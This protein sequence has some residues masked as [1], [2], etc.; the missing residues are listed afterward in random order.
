M[1]TEEEDNGIEAARTEPEAPGKAA[2][3]PRSPTGSS[4]D[5]EEKRRQDKD[6][7]QD[8]GD[9]EDEEKEERRKEEVGNDD[10]STYSS[11]S[12][13]HGEPDMEHEEVEEAVPGHELDR[14]LSRVGSPRSLRRLY[15]VSSANYTD[16]PAD[17]LSI[18][19]LCVDL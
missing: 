1:S 14:E 16:F 11:D 2:D 12:A 3:M 18:G 9:A 7:Q 4:T 10:A 17:S 13:D 6:E 5:V 8:A 15:S 19:F